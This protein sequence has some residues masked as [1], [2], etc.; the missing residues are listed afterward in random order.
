MDDD[1]AAIRRTPEA[2]TL[3][4]A[5]RVRGWLAGGW[6]EEVE[7]LLVRHRGARALES[8]GYREVRACLDG[9][10]PRSALEERIVQSTRVF[11]RRQ[12]TWL[13]GVD[14]RWI[15]QDDA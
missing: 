4:I 5:A 2:L 13:N 9:A 12:R 3:R 8:V 11:A 10:L 7:G 14:V 1:V 15:E 6:I